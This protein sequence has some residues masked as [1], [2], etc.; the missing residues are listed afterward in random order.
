MIET[1]IIKHSVSH[2]GKEIVTFECIY[3]RY[4]HAEVLTH[5]KFTR[6]SSSS[7]AIPIEKMIEEAK[8]EPV[9]FVFW[10][11]NQKGM[12]AKEQL[13]GLRLWAA[14]QVWFLAAQSAAFFATV[15][16]KIGLHK[17]NVNRLLEPFTR[18]KV[19]ITATDL[20]N[21]W[22]LRDHADAQPEIQRLASKMKDAL[23]TST[24]QKLEMG[25]WHLPYV[26]SVEGTKENLVL[27]TSLCAQVSFRSLDDT[28][29]KAK[30]IFNL[31]VE[32][33]PVH[34]S[35]TE[36]QATPLDDPEANDG[37]FTGWQQHRSLIPNNVVLG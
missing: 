10:G 19:L 15:L 30:R 16:H 34:A 23:A 6:N 9:G 33:T 12:K 7:R 32:S 37:N 21:F 29:E 8:K 25:Q 11:K 31:L 36:H 3:P 18:I 2:K 28:P 27:S 35:P 24:P 26:D 5:R 14:K 20:N 4:I 1:K 22:V 17:Q 13:T